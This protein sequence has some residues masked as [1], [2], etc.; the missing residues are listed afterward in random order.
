MICRSFGLQHLGIWDDRATFTFPHYPPWRSL[1]VRHR[2]LDSDQPAANLTL[3]SM[4]L[5][6][7]M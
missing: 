1:K 5:I 7:T 2:V 6:D 4:V 3:R